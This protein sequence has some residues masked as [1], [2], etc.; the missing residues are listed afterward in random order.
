[1]FHTAHPMDIY[2]AH[3]MERFLT[4][5]TLV[6]FLCGVNVLMIAQSTLVTESFPTFFTPVQSLPSV[7]ALVLHQVT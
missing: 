2:V 3:P 1:M 6:P 7:N 5:V 4:A